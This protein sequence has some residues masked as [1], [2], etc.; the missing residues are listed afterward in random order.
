MYKKEKKNIRGQRQKLKRW[1]LSLNSLASLA[2]WE[3]A[4]AV[5]VELSQYMKKN[6]INL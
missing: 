1:F 5:P 3:K 6:G 2:T 4:Q